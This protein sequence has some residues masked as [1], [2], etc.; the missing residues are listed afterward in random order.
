MASRPPRRALPERDRLRRAVG[1]CRSGAN[2]P[3]ALVL[4]EKERC[5]SGWGDA[6]AQVSAALALTKA[7]ACWACEAWRSV[8]PSAE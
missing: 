5:A 1:P 4:R 2:E 6:G 3:P 8:L 7:E